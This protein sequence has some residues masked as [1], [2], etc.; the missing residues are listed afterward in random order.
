MAPPNLTCIDALLYASKRA[1][2]MS[3]PSESTSRKAA[4]RGTPSRP[5]VAIALTAIG[6]SLF[7][8]AGIW[9]VEAA[10][11]L[12]S[13]IQ[14]GQGSLGGPVSLHFTC[15]GPCPWTQ[16]IVT[17]STGCFL[18]VAALWMYW[19]PRYHVVEGL[20]VGVVA[21]AGEILLIGPADVGP[22][23]PALVAAVGGV[24]AIV[25]SPSARAN[26]VR[27]GKHPLAP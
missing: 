1:I 26:R 19:R 18:V 17:L 10:E 6:A 20:L 8:L 5:L 16:A 23:L 4:G 25:W 7:V 2:A 15:V 12:S 11:G 27:V 21:A 22:L 13:A 3:V 24:W 9:A 14:Q